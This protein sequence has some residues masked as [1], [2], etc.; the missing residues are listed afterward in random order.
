MMVADTQWPRWEVFKQ[1]SPSRPHQ[2]IGTVH[3]ADAEHALLTARNVFVR[4]PSAVSLWV[5]P[6]E[7]VLVVTQEELQRGVRGAHEE[8]AALGRFQVFCKTTH[9]QSLAFA[10][11]QGE[12]VA[13]S[14]WEA[15]ERARATF[16]VRSP[17]AW[18]IVP[19]AAICR[20]RDEDAPSWFDPAK[21]KTYKQQSAYGTVSAS[22]RKKARAG[23]G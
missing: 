12:V 11:H 9:K 3:A 7:R 2:A 14:P 19:E 8:A 22:P 18:M 23:V 15:L 13:R 6:A 10:D 20:T 16:A 5:A 17:L 4:R 21:T 1:D